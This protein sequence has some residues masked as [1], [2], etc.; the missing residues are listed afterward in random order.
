MYKTLLLVI[1]TALA[2]S[3]WGCS[4]DGDTV[5]ALKLSSR[6]TER[7][8]AAAVPL[9]LEASGGATSQMKESEVD[10]DSVH[11]AT[12]SCHHGTGAPPVELSIKAFYTS[13]ALYMRL[14]W[15]DPTMD[16][17]RTWSW[18]KTGW[19][20]GDGREDGAGILWGED[21][22]FDCVHSCHLKDW[23]MAG[24]M[25]ATADFAMET[26]E[27]T[28]KDFWIWRSGRGGSG[29]M[30]EDATLS[31]RGR[32]SD[33]GEERELFTPNSRNAAEGDKEIFTDGDVPIKHPEEKLNA[34]APGE[35]LADESYDRLEVSANGEY[36]EGRWVV[37]LSRP[38]APAGSAD[39]TFY[40]G[41]EYFF[42][43]AVID[44]V[45]TDHNAGRFPL[46]LK[47]VEPGSITPPLED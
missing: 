46:R 21:E 6:P 31:E 16:T 19:T 7:E 1:L 44:G 15:K 35:L 36:R 41:G 38:L 3:L 4:I 5:Y 34:S 22:N 29:G 37:T 39:V 11:V 43:V 13:E 20:P 30:A 2:L 42:G 24:E 8:W 25:K 28:L 12:A 10:E 18:S 23:R 14:E 17:G 32:V 9:R 40:A 33:T 47:L 27:G 45:G 26:S